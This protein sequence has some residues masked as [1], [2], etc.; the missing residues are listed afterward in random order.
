MKKWFALY[1]KPR[2]EFKALEQI[3][4]LANAI[5]EQNI[6][7]PNG[8]LV[9]IELFAH[10]ALCVAISGKCYMS[11]GVYNQS[12]SRGACFQNCRRKYRITDVETGD[13]LEIQNQ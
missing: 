12:A 1:T 11:L 6:T 7:G 4:A 2:H 13:E 10:G 8:K 3:S 9:Q 5:R